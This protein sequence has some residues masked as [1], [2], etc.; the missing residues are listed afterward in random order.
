MI[1]I[2]PIEIKIREFLPKLFLAY[3]IIKKTDHSVIFA[4]QRFMSKVFKEFKNAIYFD[5][6]THIS[7]IENNPYYKN[8][9]IFMLDEE[10][11]VSLLDKDTIY[12]HYHPKMRDYVNNFLFWGK[13]D[14]EKLKKNTFKKGK[15][16]ILG[17]PKFDYLKDKYKDIFIDEVQKIKKKYKKFVFFSSS[18]EDINLKKEIISSQFTTY[19]NHLSKSNIEKK[20]NLNLKYRRLSFNN[21]KKTIKTLKLLASRNPKINFIFRKHPHEKIQ[22]VKKLFKNKP[23]NLHIVYKHTVTPWIMACDIYMHSGCT[24]SLEASILKKE[25]FCYIPFMDFKNSRYVKLSKIGKFYRKSNELINN[26][27]KSLKKKIRKKSNIKHII[28][29]SD[30]RSFTDSFIKLIKKYEK[31]NSEIVYYNYSKRLIY[32]SNLKFWFFKFLSI[33]KNYLL[34]TKF[35]KFIPEKFS[36][37]KEDKINK[38]KKITKKEM[39]S[40]ISKIQLIEKNKMII[41]IKEISDSVF[42]MEKKNF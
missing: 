4:G 12:I 17:H 18:F 9:I 5:K 16:H 31:I 2:I 10:G 1:V 41:N 19:Y 21:Y 6:S 14:L 37:T 22:N 39:V 24:T 36:F 42:L 11:P 35:A 27:E 13:N 40:T 3:Q 7:R 28:E 33:I 8:N 32:L 30:K 34:T 23:K 29:N 25:I 38:L 20:V 15:V 26:L